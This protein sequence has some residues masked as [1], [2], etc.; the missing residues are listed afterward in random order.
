MVVKKR[1][2]FSFLFLWSLFS[3]GNAVA[4]TRTEYLVSKQ[5]TCKILFEDYVGLKKDAE[6]T[7]QIS[8]PSPAA[9]EAQGGTKPAIEAGALDAADETHSETPAPG[10]PGAV[11]PEGEQSPS[12]STAQPQVV[13]IRIQGVNKSR[14]LYNGLRMGSKPVKLPDLFLEIKIKKCPACAWHSQFFRSFY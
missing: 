4:Q 12:E 8:K 9:A 2:S 7:V 14:A 13:R 5:K 1:T 3:S 11:Q 6:L 10:A